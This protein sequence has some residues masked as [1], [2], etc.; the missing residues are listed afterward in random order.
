M[1]INIIKPFKIKD[2]KKKNYFIFLTNQDF[3]TL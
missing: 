1:N 3:K 2:L